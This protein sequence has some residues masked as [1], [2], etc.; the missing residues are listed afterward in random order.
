MRPSHLEAAYTKVIKYIIEEKNCIIC[1]N[2][3]PCKLSLIKEI[4]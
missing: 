3:N 1:F 2:N 4:I